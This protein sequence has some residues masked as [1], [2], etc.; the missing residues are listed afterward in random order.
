M[1][2]PYDYSAFHPGYDGEETTFDFTMNRNVFLPE[3]SGNGTSMM[4][5]ESILLPNGESQDLGA[6]IGMSYSKIHPNPPPPKDG[7]FMP[8]LRNDAHVVMKKIVGDEFFADF[9]AKTYV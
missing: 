5:G 9:T 8:A 1:T 7:G 4:F 6:R 3:F 2:K